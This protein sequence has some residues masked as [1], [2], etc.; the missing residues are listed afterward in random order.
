MFQFFASQSYVSLF[1]Y[2]STPNPVKGTFY[3][4]LQFSTQKPHPRA[5]HVSPLRTS[6]NV[7]YVYHISQH[8][9]SGRK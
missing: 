8:V 2:F 4:M 5:A 7:E 1:E 9:L 6:E 3:V